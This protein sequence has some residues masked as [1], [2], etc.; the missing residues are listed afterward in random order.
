FVGYRKIDGVELRVNV[1][2]SAQPERIARQLAE[3]LSC[4]HAFPVERAAQLK[5]RGASADDWRRHYQELFRRVSDGVLPLLE[6]PVRAKA[7]ALWERF[8]TD[9]ANFAFRP[10]LIHRDLSSAHILY[11]TASSALAGIIDWGDAWIGDPALDFVGLLSE[12]G[13]EFT[14]ATLAGYRGEQDAT[15]W[16]RMHFYLRV[17]PFHE[18]LYGVQ[19]GDE[20]HIRQ[21]VEGIEQALA[22]Q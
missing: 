14:E 19:E 4:L 2:A 3:F 10:V 20:T 13:H 21:G 18:V 1:L 15:F 7:A 16:R 8:L 9:D 5:V 6:A 17:V 11:D 22:Q 12:Y